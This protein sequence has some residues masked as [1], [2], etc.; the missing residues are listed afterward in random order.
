VWAAAD[1]ADP[2]DLDVARSLLC[3]GFVL[4]CLW[5]TFALSVASAPAWAQSAPTA[6]P[7]VVDKAAQT[8]A[9]AEK[10]VTTLTAQRAQLT[11]KLAQQVA[12]SDTLKKQKA[13]WRRDR[14]LKSALAASND[15]ATKLTALDKQL[16]A[17]KK[18]L[19]AARQAEVAAI[20][21]ELK[22]GPPPARVD[23]LNKLR[24]QLAPA[25]IAPKKIVI[26]DA[27]IDPLADPEDLER[28]AAAIAAAEKALE[29]Q[30]TSL[31][32]QHTDLVAMANLR[33]AHERA[34][35]MFTR[36]DDTP[37][38]NAPRGGTGRG[39]N[40]EVAGAPESGDDASPS[41]GGNGSG[42]TTG[43]GGGSTGGDLFDGTKTT[44]ESTAAVALGE[45]IDR[46][47]IDGMLR[48]QRSGDP[49]QRAA[50]AAQARDAVQKRLELL[51]KKRAMIEKRAKAL[52][53]G[54]EVMPRTE[55]MMFS[56]LGIDD[57]SIVG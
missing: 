3:N 20:D 48:A 35:E 24:A 51:K 42:S 13:S 18:A 1:T 17:A 34:G 11:T 56:E 26:P 36:D 54:A 23:Q 57:A 19:A 16:A 41:S 22:A 49:K 14:E 45:V 47:T 7:A 28:Q 38:R 15:T 9:A 4:R 40:Q 25:P 12:T 10:K 8:T 37:H 44:F 6:Q 43:T 32:K 27:E 46:S 5:L 39:G 21:A 50:A 2:K 30:H 53:K 33:S 29:Q 31:D 52:R 55:E